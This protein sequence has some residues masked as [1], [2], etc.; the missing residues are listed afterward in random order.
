MNKNGL[1]L[2][3]GISAIDG[4]TPVVA[5]ATDIKRKTKNKKLSK[6]GSKIVQVWYL[7]QDVSP[8]DAVKTGEDV[9]V[10]GDCKHRPINGGACYV[11]TFQAP[12]AVWKSYK[13]GSY[14][15]WDGDASIFD[16]RTVRFGAWGDPAA[17]PVGTLDSIRDVAGKI[18]AYT[19]QW[20]DK[21]FEA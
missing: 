21:K 2:W 7:L 20:N 19:H 10:C 4:K 15:R 11:I 1:I 8:V 3:E 14:A 12:R 13:R 17:I 16:G 6:R 18:M 5:I 9:A